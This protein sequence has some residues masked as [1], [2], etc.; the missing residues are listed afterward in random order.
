LA[1]FPV[2]VPPL[3]EHKED[4]P[5]LAEHFLRLFGAEMGVHSPEIIDEA[6]SVMQ[7]YAFP[8]NIRELKNVIERALIE[9]GGE[10][11]KPKHLHLNSSTPC[12][13]SFKVCYFNK[14]FS[15]IPTVQNS[16]C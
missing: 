2:H 11:I 7:S 8:G 14:L 5:F 9:S 13:T 1:S 3:R 12:V 16:T 10:T 15:E 4:I 6:L